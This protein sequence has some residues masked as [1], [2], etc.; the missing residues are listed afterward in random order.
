RPRRTCRRRAP[1]SRRRQHVDLVG[2]DPRP[3]PLQSPRRHRPGGPGSAGLLWSTESETGQGLDRRRRLPAVSAVDYQGV[4]F[5]YPD[6]ADLALAGVDLTVAEGQLV[7]VV[8]PSGS[9]KS[10]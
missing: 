3:A 10:T 4:T 1:R 2:H 9:G 6:D 8:G 5:A 7:L